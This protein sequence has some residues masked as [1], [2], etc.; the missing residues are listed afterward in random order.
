[1]DQDS[2]ARMVR[3]AAMNSASGGRVTARTVAPCSASAAATPSSP[4][5]TSSCACASAS[6][7]CRT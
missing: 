6:W 3:L 4:A 1:M 2:A 7:K 5:A